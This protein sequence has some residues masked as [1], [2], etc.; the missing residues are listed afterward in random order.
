MGLDSVELIMEI[1]DRFN[2]IIP[3]REASEAVTVEK[4]FQCIL[5]STKVS[6][7]KK[8]IWDMLVL[9][10]SEQLGVDKED[11]KPESN[12]VKDFGL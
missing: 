6:S 10:I 9:I 1:E 12:F 4:L 7:D 11:I 3:D 2:I 5:N 8:E